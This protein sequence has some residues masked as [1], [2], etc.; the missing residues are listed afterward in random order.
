MQLSVRSF[1]LADTP[2]LLQLAKQALDGL[3]ERRGGLEFQEQ[4]AQFQ[5]IKATE[6]QQRLLEV[7]REVLVG[8]LD[9]QAFG[10][11]L[12][13]HQ[14]SILTAEALYV[15]PEAREVGLGS[16]LLQAAELR[17]RELKCSRFEALALPGDRHMKQRAESEAMKARLLVLSKTLDE[18]Q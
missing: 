2:Q 12:V 15:D 9:G 5:D 16:A 3:A 14:D 8:L 10:L 11:C 7:N 17:A 18:R 6:I 4:F 13:C 1:E